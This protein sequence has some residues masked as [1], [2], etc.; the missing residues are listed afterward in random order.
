M[1]E[2]KARERRSNGDILQGP[3]PN[4][5]DLA[6]TREDRR[7]KKFKPRKYARQLEDSNPMLIGA[8]IRKWNRAYGFGSA[9]KST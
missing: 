9:S 8:S 6:D 1:S 7:L 2:R 4:L 5:T 3:G